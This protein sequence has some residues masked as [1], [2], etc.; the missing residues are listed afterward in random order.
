MSRLRATSDLVGTGGRYF[1][2]GVGRRLERR[3]A[4]GIPMNR[5]RHGRLSSL[6]AQ[7]DRTGHLVD[8]DAVATLNRTKLVAEFGRSRRTIRR[9]P[10]HGPFDGRGHIGG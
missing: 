4:S 2:A 3:G 1:V 5:A 6:H 8:A 10:G 7:T 9:I